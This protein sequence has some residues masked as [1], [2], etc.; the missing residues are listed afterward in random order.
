MSKQQGR[1]YNRRDFVITGTASAAA[2]G[3]STTKGWTETLAAPSQSRAAQPSGN[4]QHEN[5]SP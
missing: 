3:M 1:S 5:R 4:V 2:A